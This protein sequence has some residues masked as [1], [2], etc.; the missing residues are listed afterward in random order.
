MT[1]LDSHCHLGAPDF[2][3]DREAVLDRAWASGVE[4]LVAIGS[5]YGIAGNA[6]ALELA[7]ADPRVRA[8]VGVQP[9]EDAELDGQGRENLTA[10]LEHRAVAARDETWL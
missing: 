10:W 4:G 1:W 6:L 3:A 8:T 7:S 5:G 9:N 2:D